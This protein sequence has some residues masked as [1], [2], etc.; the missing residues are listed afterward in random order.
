MVA[1]AVSP[2]CSNSLL[3]TLWQTHARLA[4]H[5]SRDGSRPPPSKGG[6]VKSRVRGKA[7]PS[8]SSHSPADSGA[9]H[10]AGDL[11]TFAAAVLGVREDIGSF[12]DDGCLCNFHKP[13]RISAEKHKSDYRTD[14]QL[15]LIF[16]SN[17][18]ESYYHLGFRVRRHSSAFIANH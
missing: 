14:C 15:P 5:R 18:S 8:I 16:Q 12:A 10:K 9:D 2:H 11:G 6:K 1:Y 13:I 3:L 7:F 17:S 4:F